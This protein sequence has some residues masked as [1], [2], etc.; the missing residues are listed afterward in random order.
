MLIQ[1]KIM[2]FC[3][4]T[5]ECN[6]HSLYKESMVSK[7]LLY[8]VLQIKILH[9]NKAWESNFRP[10]IMICYQFLIWLINLVHPSKSFGK[11][12]LGWT[13]YITPYKSSTKSHYY[14]MDNYFPMIGFNI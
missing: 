4:C 3:G 10:K 12:T 8:I 7:P 2:I 1:L 14:C 9:T 5:L 6:E 11:N 13:I